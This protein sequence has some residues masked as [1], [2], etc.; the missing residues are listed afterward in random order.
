[1]EQ[2]V[3]ER[4]TGAI[5][6]VAIVVIVVPELLTGPRRSS[7]PEPP[8]KSVTLDLG[9]DAHRVASTPAPVTV[10]V[11][12]STPPPATVPVVPA[13][14]TAPPTDTPPPAA[15][16]DAAQNPESATQAPAEPTASANGGWVVQL[17]SFASRDNAQ[18]LVQELRHKGYAAFES[19]FHG[20]TRVLY[21][22]RVGPEQDR[23]RAEVV[24]TRL[25]REGYRGSVTAQP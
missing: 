8:T 10:P 20:T 21:R 18:R 23:A 16:P 7:T 22:V 9:G 14:P 3:K 6:L 19:E 11:A 4:L 13:A 1:M 15:A 17:G 25:A 5:V 2:R 12:A 24:A